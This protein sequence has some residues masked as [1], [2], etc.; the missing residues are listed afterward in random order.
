MPPVDQQYL[1]NE[2]YKVADLHRDG[3]FTREEALRELAQRCPGFTRSEYERAFSLG[4]L[5]SR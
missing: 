1:E 2:A 3:R 5:E 4:L